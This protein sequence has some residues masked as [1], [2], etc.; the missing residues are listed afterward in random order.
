MTGRTPR[1][2]GSRQAPGSGT[3]R[4][5]GLR[6]ITEAR[7]RLLLG[8]V[9]VAYGLLMSGAAFWLYGGFR[10]L[11]ENFGFDWKSTFMSAAF[12][13]L[14]L[15][16]PQLTAALLLRRSPLVVGRTMKALWLASAAA[17]LLGCGLSEALILADERAFEAEV[18]ERGNQ[19]Y[20]RARSW[21]HGDAGLVYNAGTFHATD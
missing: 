17:W 9:V 6:A 16:L 2:A 20:S 8:L 12:T 5:V 18:R 10:T 14:F 13:A 11:G 3:Q 19:S 15:F 21:P 4:S 1:R 7:R